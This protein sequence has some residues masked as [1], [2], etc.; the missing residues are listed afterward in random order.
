MAKSQSRKPTPPML[1]TPAKR[2][3]RLEGDALYAW[4]QY[5]QKIEQLLEGKQALAVSLLTSQGY[6]PGKYLLS[7]DG[8]IV[9]PEQMRRFQ[10]PKG[11]QIAPTPAPG[12][13]DS[14]S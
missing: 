12:S 3:P 14:E 9:T 11:E 13:P 5:I 4:A 8:Y 10:Q 6:E 1:M 2:P 7:D